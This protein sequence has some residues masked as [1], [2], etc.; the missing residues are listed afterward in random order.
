MTTKPSNDRVAPLCEAWPKAFTT[1]TPKPLKLGI[2]LDMASDKFTADEISVLLRIYV[3]RP[4]YLRALVAGSFRI[5][6][7]GKPTAVRVTSE[8]EAHAKERLAKLDAAKAAKKAVKV[9]K[10]AVKPVETQEANPRLRSPAKTIKNANK[11]PAPKPQP[12]DLK[13]P[14]PAGS[15][16]PRTGRVVLGLRRS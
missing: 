7:D 4:R 1:G 12:D 16:N 15:V 10:K 14:A 2:H 5:G 8:E 9:A 13:A 11:D 3:G 6:L